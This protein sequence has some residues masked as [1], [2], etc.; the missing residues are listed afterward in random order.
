MNSCLGAQLLKPTTLFSELPDQDLLSFAGANDRAES[1]TMPSG[2]QPAKKRSSAGTSNKLVA[3]P[4]SIDEVIRVITNPK[5]FPAPVRPIGSNSTATR[6]NRVQTGT[7][8]DTTKMNRVLRITKDSIT[9]QAGA[10]LHEVA[11]I[12]AEDGLELA[13]G[14]E[15][16]DR[17]IG[18]MIASP[19]HSVG[20]PGEPDH[21]GDSVI[22]M[23]VVTPTGQKV[24]IPAEH[25]RYMSLFRHSYGLTGVI[26]HVT[27]KARPIR[28]YKVNTTK[29]VLDELA[30][31]MPNIV[32]VKVGM[33]MHLMP[34]RNRAWVELRRP[35]EDQKPIKNIPWKVKEWARSSAMPKMVESVGK[36]FSMPGIRDPLID[37]L[38]EATQKL[39]VGNF[40]DYSSNAAE[41]TSKPKPKRGTNDDEVS[42]SWAFPA[43][44]F[45]GV[46]SAFKDFS[47]EH[48][49]QHGFR[50]DLPAFVYRLNENKDAMLSPSFEGPVFVLRLSSILASGWDDFVAELNELAVKH[51]G[52]PL[53]TQTRGFT[54]MRASQV[55][56]MRLRA[57]R[58]ARLKLDPEGRLLNQFYSEYVA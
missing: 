32:D 55:Y 28:A 18:G 5:H 22:S 37:S 24:T 36:A 51:R 11:S 3:H 41:M 19:A 10:R 16:P 23:I 7:I 4:K 44:Q 34:F 54:S 58:N 53:F 25:K 1:Q 26:C 8:L 13:A 2:S 17:T 56:G 38:T 35:C 14:D 49:K 43:D 9:V 30:T 15:M 29:L 12:L 42:C 39:F 48:Y 27:L 31:V 20:Y 52:I 46:L 47:I 50:C 40:A 33:R 57:F 21:L 45:G 6:A